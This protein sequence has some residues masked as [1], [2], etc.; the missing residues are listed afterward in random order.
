M[1]QEYANDVNVRFI[2]SY[3]LPENRLDP[4]SRSGEVF[5]EESFNA[6]IGCLQ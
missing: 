5:V 1:D 2:I 4:D 3:I 6:Y